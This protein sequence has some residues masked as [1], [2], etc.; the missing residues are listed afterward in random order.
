MLHEIEDVAALCW[1][2][3]ILGCRRFAGAF[4]YLLAC[5]LVQEAG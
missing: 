3:Q 2:V 5:G 1:Q 4:D